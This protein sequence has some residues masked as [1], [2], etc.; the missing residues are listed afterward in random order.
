MVTLGVEDEQGRVVAGDLVPVVGEGDDL[1]VLAGFGQ[2]GVGVDQGAGGG[3]FGEEGEHRAGALGA[4]GH[5]VLFQH[6][7][8]APVHDGVEVQV[9][10]LAV[11]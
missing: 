6:R 8:I 3:V 1:A 10:C 9:Q 7:V 2:V 5:V 4:A 11:G